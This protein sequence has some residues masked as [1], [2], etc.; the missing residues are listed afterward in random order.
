MHGPDRFV[1]NPMITESG[2][3][4]NS[5]SRDCSNCNG[6]TPLTFRLATTISHIP[7]GRP[8]HLA[9]LR[10]AQV[11]LKIQALLLLLIWPSHENQNLTL[12]A[13][14]LRAS[15]WCARSQGLLKHAVG[16]F[17]PSR[18][19]FHQAHHPL[20]ARSFAQMILGITSGGATIYN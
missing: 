15:R 3:E 8:N 14:A 4:Q 10:L 5:L 1:A 7:R 11:P 17:K 18:C 6:V 9:K 13:G 16:H 2:S 12:L 20:K 19:V